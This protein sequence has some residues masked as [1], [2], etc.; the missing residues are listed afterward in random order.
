VPQKKSKPKFNPRLLRRVQKHIAEE[1]NRLVMG[2]VIRLK[3]D[4]FGSNKFWGDNAQ[5]VN[6]AKCGTAACMAGWTLALSGFDGKKIQKL[7]TWDIRA[8]KLLGL[9]PDQATYLF[10]DGN[11]VGGFSERYK[12]AKTQKQRAKIAVEY[13]DYF[14]KHKDNLSDAA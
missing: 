12:E 13:I 5:E 7:T 2:R 9:T 6:F 14:I 8:R 1:P 11:W 3:V 10:Y 4:L